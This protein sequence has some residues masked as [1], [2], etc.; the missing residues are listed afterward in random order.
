M[1]GEWSSY[2]VRDFIPVTRDAYLRM[3]EQISAAYGPLYVF[4]LASALVLVA[5][6][7]TGR[8]HVA[9]L[10]LALIWGWVGYSFLLQFYAHLNWASHW[11]GIAFYVEALLLAVIM[12]S[13][14]DTLTAPAPLYRLGL[15]LCVAGLGWPLLTRIG[16]DGWSQVEVVGMHPDPTAVLTLGLGLLVLR[17]WRLW[18]IAAIPLFWC[19]LSGLTLGVLDLPQANMLY[20]VVGIGL[21]AM[22]YGTLTNRMK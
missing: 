5:L 4:M 21:G 2:A 6:T 3:L 15:M 22:V 19:L 16:R 18:V 12:G 1:I 9:G 14:R 13:V 11:F 7:L 8:R 17:G 20:G 10:L